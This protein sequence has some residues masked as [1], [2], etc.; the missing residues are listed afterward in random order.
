[1]RARCADKD[2][3]CMFRSECDSRGRCSCLEQEWC[4]LRRGVE[5]VWRVEGKVLAAVVDCS[6]LRGVGVDS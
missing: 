1:M 2:P 3:L 6:Y 5:D 4:T